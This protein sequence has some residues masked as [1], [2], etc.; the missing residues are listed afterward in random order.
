MESNKSGKVILRE[1]VLNWALEARSSLADKKG[2][3]I[4]GPGSSTRCEI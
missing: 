4:S 3:D 1:G 2:R